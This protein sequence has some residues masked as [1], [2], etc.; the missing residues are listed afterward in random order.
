MACIDNSAD[1]YTVVRDVLLPFKKRMG[2]YAQLI[3][4]LESNN[5]IIERKKKAGVP[6]D[7]ELEKIQSINKNLEQIDLYRNK[8]F[9]LLS[10][11]N[12]SEYEVIY[13]HYFL[14]QKMI[15]I[16]DDL[17]Y[18]EKTIYTIKKQAL[19][20]LEK[21]YTGGLYNDFKPDFRS[22]KRFNCSR[23]NG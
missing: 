5:R 22:P 17:Y 8:A 15:D 2:T 14:G 18:C 23:Y 4:Q 12:G 16:A 20:K 6:Y 1:K 3:S 13:R 10:F 11:L 21:L 7:F 9:S 19:T